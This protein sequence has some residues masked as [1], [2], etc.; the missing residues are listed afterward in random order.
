MRR[1][2]T[3]SR[4]ACK[5]AVTALLFVCMFHVSAGPVSA[6]RLKDLTDIKGVRKNQL[7]G[8]GLIVGL[9]GT[10]DGKDSKFTFQSLA[11]LLER[12]GVTV[13]PKKI[14]K[15]ANVAA[16]MVTANLP[17]FGRV[18]TQMDVTVSSIGDAESLTGGTLLVTPLRAANGKVYAAAQGPVNTGGYSV[19]GNAAKVTK[20]FPTVGRIVS[21]ATIEREI[22]NDFMGKGVLALTLPNPDFTNATRIAKVINRAFNGNMAK[23]IDAGTIEVSVPKNYRGN[24]VGLVAMIEQL[25]V[26]PD[27][28]SKV[29]INER[30]GTVVIGENVRLSTVAIAH[31]NLSIEIKE[32]ANVSQPMPF[33]NN[34]NV[35]LLGGGGKDGQAPPKEVGNNGAIVAPG[36]NTVVTNDTN[37]N[38]K[39]E[40]A[41]LM[42]LRSGVTI[43]Q[44]VRALNALGVTPRDLMTIF[45]SLK[46]AGALQAR[47]EVM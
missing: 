6:I 37:I 5:V 30:T 14:Q 27:Q 36:G 4:H 41:R 44:V 8:Y 2:L 40:N 29:V 26:I 1:F 9:A 39:E 17:A 31:G 19:S 18:G 11:S 46:A 34:Q 42:L 13:D 22:P 28:S 10:G 23:T 32:T 45:Q 35:G 20:N 43:S 3:H 7:V 38:V 25:E 15:V 16:V 33:A 47:L 24:T 21:G 12:M